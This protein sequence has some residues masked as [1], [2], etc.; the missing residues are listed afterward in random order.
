MWPQHIRGA[1][2]VLV[3][4]M[5]KE[6]LGDM[7]VIVRVT[8]GTSVNMP[9]PHAVRWQARGWESPGLKFCHLCAV[10]I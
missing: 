10:G 5:F 8:Q 4:L 6:T 1:H 9:L 3:E 7:Q 2:T